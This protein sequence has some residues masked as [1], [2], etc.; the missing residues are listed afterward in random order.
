MPVS[1][2]S[3]DIRDARLGNFPAPAAP[4]LQMKT[5]GL[6]HALKRQ[7]RGGLH[8]RTGFALMRRD[9]SILA[10]RVSMVHLVRHREP[11]CSR[12]DYIEGGYDVPNCP[13]P[14]LWSAKPFG[15]GAKRAGRP[16]TCKSKLFTGRPIELTAQT[17]KQQAGSADLPVLVD[18][19]HHVFA[20]LGCA[21]ENMVQAARVRASSGSA[22]R[23]RGARNTG[24][25]GDRAARTDGPIQHHPASSI[26]ARC[27]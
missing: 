14:Q 7:A 13:M 11:M 25:P 18:D 2:P 1:F 22:L 24:R 12:P 4:S 9:R 23:P 20:S 8:G 10:R 6:E 27:L 16:L 21:V 3:P 17:F 15:P 5:T 26:D 19:N